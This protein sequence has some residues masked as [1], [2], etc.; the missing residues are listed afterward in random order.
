PAHLG[1]RTCMSWTKTCFSLVAATLVVQASVAHAGFTS[2]VIREG[3]GPPATPPVI[4][5][6]GGGLT[7]FVIAEGGQ[8]AGLGSN[9]INGATIGQISNLSITRHDDTT[10]F[11]A[12][13]G[14]AVAP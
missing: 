1:R 4:N 3:G 7:E 14:P 10:R 12:G 5:D 6:L 8:K 9:D 2:F 13:S 11:T